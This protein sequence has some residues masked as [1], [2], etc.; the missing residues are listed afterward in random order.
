MAS[1]QEDYTNKETLRRRNHKASK[2]ET[3]TFRGPKRICV[4]NIGH[5]AKKNIEAL[6]TRFGSI[7]ETNMP[8]DRV[9]E[10]RAKFAFMTI[11][12]AEN[13]VMAIATL[14]RTSFKARTL[15]LS[16]PEPRPRPLESHAR[17][18]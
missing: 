4:R 7:T 14:N 16:P 9:T 3:K 5:P 11:M 13:V 15:H 10:R 17:P 1:I 2:A 8:I 12:M 6:F 18:L